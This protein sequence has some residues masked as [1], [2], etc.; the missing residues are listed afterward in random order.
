VAPA[1]GTV[2]PAETPVAAPA[3]PE[4]LASR[5]GQAQEWSALVE[6]MMAVIKQRMELVVALK[7]DSNS[8]VKPY[9]QGRSATR[10]LIQVARVQIKKA[11]TAVRSAKAQVRSSQKKAGPD[12]F[13]ELNATLAQMTRRL[14]AHSEQL[15]KNG[16]ELDAANQA[17]SRR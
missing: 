1:G 15:D 8:A 4:S 13:K 3:L 16:A 17:T 7:D 2:T 10:Q 12:A 11:R 6:G 5:L 14:T 9:R